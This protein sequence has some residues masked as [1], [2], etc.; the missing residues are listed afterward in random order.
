MKRTMRLFSWTLYIVILVV[1]ILFST[2]LENAIAIDPSASDAAILSALEQAIDAME[3]D[4]VDMKTKNRVVSNKDGDNE[5]SSLDGPFCS[6]INYDMY[7]ITENPYSSG[8]VSVSAFN[9]DI[10]TS[11][12]TNTFAK[13]V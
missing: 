4:G 12:S 11:N 9:S 13:N 6:I 1:E 8:E 3:D 7:G 2:I 10:R 5:C